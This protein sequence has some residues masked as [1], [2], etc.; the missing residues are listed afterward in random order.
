MLTT[1][2]KISDLE[3]AQNKMQE[4]FFIEIKRDPSTMEVTT[5]PPS[6]DDCIENLGH[7]SLSLN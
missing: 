1:D 4:Q 3:E 2:R 6:F 5:L 7:G